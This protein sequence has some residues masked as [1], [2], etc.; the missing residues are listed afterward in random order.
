M[1]VCVFVDDRQLSG[2]KGAA[3]WAKEHSNIEDDGWFTSA[4]YKE[5]GPDRWKE[6]I[7]SNLQ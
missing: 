5:H 3:L 7:T 2:W 6:H 1:Y 4:D